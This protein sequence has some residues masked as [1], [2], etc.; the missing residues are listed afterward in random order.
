MKPTVPHLIIELEIW[1]HGSDTLRSRRRGLDYMYVAVVLTDAIAIVVVFDG[2][3][4]R[5]CASSSTISQ[6]SDRG[7]GGLYVRTVSA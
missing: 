3:E 5:F 4:G 6:G 1:H 7:E 2:V